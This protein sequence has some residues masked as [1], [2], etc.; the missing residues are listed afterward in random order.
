M[1]RLLEHKFFFHFLFEGKSLDSNAKRPHCWAY[2]LFRWVHLNLIK[3]FFYKDN[4]Y[5]LEKD[6]FHL[7]PGNFFFTK[8][9]FN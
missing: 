9:T 4:I 2:I 7:Q 3:I 1:R 5:K 6:D 8:T